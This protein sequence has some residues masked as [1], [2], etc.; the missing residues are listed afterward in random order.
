MSKTIGKV[1]KSKAGSNYIKL[2]QDRDKEGRLIGKSAVELFPITLADGTV[3][4]E[5]DAIFLKDPRVELD[6]LA[7]KGFIA[8]DVA[9]A[10]RAK[11]PE[12]VRYKVQLGTKG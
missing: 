10:R 4:N 8:A 2:G 5:G 12:F 3:L 1:L 7:L 9:E 11:I 6:E